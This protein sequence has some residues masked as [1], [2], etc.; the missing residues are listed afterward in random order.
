[1]SPCP[2]VGPY[3][4]Q[5]RGWRVVEWNTSTAHWRCSLR[6]R[7]AALFQLQRCPRHSAVDP[8]A[9]I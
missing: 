2:C 7:D 6:G 3:G 5:W 9:L 1:M 4:W 8:A